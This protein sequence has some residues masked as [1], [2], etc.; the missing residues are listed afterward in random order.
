MKS[1]LGFVSNSSSSSFLIEKKNVSAWQI[2]GVKEHVEY[3]PLGEAWH[4]EDTGNFILAETPMDNFDLR[5]YAVVYLHI[6][7]E[8]LIVNGSAM[9]RIIA[10]ER[11]K[12][13]NDEDT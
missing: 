3:A 5:W 7:E 13:R 12:E 2:S 8:F 10:A 11:Q 1:R 6:P 9:N 4:V